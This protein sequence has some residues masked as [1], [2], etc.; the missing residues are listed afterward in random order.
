MS[1]ASQKVK[2]ILLDPG[3]YNLEA[4]F[5][6]YEYESCDDIEEWDDNIEGLRFDGYVDTWKPGKGSLIIEADGIT[7]RSSLPARP[8]SINFKSDYLSEDDPL[9]HNALVIKLMMCGYMTSKLLAGSVCTL[10]ER[11]FLRKIVFS[12][13][14]LLFVVM[15]P[16]SRIASSAMETTVEFLL[17]V[18]SR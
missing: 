6:S 8:A 1:V 15:M 9:I 16:L 18:I 13:E 7:L 10:L 5:N 17:L 14:Q 11:R 12:V 3:N 4:K 2:T